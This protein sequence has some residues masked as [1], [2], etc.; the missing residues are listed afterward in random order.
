MSKYNISGLDFFS[1]DFNMGY[2]MFTRPTQLKRFLISA[3]NNLNIKLIILAQHPLTT[4]RQKTYRQKTTLQS[5]TI[6]LM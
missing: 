3:I 1:V 6:S 2:I 4:F 5:K